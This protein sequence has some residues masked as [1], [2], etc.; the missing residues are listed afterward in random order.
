MLPHLVIKPVADVFQQSE[1]VD[2][3]LG[4]NVFAEPDVEG[5]V[6]LQAQFLLRDCAG[7]LETLGLAEIMKV[8][9]V[10]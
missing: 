2:M 8:L 4:L 9:F 7:G 5:L 6:L 10:R 1:A 3:L